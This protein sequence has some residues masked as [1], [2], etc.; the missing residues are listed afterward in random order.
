VQIAPLGIADAAYPLLIER[1]RFNQEHFFLYRDADSGFNHGFLSGFFASDPVALQKIQL[2]AACVNDPASPDGCTDDANALDRER[3]TVLRLE[4][5]ALLPGEFCGLNVEEPEGWAG[6]RSSGSCGYDLRGATHLLF[7]V[8][9]PTPFGIRVRFGVAGHDG[10]FVHVPYSQIFTKISI[11]LDSLGLTDAD[12]ADVHILLTI[13]TND[14]NATGG[15]IILD[16]ARF[17][18]VPVAQQHALSLPLANETFGVVPLQMPDPGRVPIPPDQL[19]RSVATTYEASLACRSLVARAGDAS[20]SD[21][22]RASCVRSA[23]LIAD[24]LCYALDHDNS[25]LPLPV[26]PRGSHGLHSAMMAGDL[27]LYNTQ[28]PGAGQQ[29]EIRLAGF[30]AS[31]E[32]CGGTG[33]CLVLDGATGGNAA[34]A[35]IGL[36]AAYECEP[37]HDPRYLD[38]ART[39]GRWI[40]GNLADTSGDGFGGYYLGYPDEGA[41]KKLVR[42]KSTENNA[43]IFAALTT[44]ARVER[45]LGNDAE[46]EQWTAAANTGGDF[47]MACFDAVEGRFNAGSVPAGTPPG[48]G[49][50]PTGPQQG[51][52]VINVADFLDA[53]TLAVLALSESDRYRGATDWRRPVQYVLDHFVQTVTVGSDNYSG[54]N[55]VHDAP[56]PDGIAWEFTAQIV[57]AMR[58]VD[59]LYQESQFEERAAFYLGQIREAQLSAPFGDGRGVVAATL[60]DGDLLPPIEQALTTPFQAIPQRVGLAATA[61]AIF[62]EANSNVLSPSVDAP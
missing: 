38:A 45:E 30:T 28:G 8:R 14:V 6:G 23:R 37:T 51:N 19:L 56:R 49:I 31:P 4:F 58:W 54:F 3:G 10:P 16:N 17:E 46:A 27:L 57:L 62:A 12:L 13:A 15:T 29:G 2:D 24:A 60:Q 33:F 22:E 26:A 11:P 41:P 9:S 52:D 34:F 21:E 47:V 18:P 32:L 50:D 53:N 5:A 59:G 36:A 7:D 61:W 55:L 39:I 40:V 48:F 20:T 42:S 43:D 35:V 44:L 1:T 25:G